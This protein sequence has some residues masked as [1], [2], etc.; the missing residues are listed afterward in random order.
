MGAFVTVLSSARRLLLL[1]GGA[2]PFKRAANS[3]VVTGEY[4]RC[5]QQ[6]IQIDIDPDRMLTRPRSKRSGR[7]RNSISPISFEAQ[8]S[9]SCG[10]P[11]GHHADLTTHG[12]RKSVTCTRRTDFSATAMSPLTPKAS[13]AFVII[14]R[15]RWNPAFSR[16]LARSGVSNVW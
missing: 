4:T 16:R 11:L 13:S 2:S 6:R 9:D 3:E 1:K 8:G 7:K 14:M 12:I 10:C 15:D 5:C